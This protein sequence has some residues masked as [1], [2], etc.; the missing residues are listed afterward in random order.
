MVTWQT[1]ARLLL[2]SP[3]KCLEKRPKGRKQLR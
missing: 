3:P 2:E 1:A